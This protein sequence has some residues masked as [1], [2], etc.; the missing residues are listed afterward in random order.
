MIP[1]IKIY[2]VSYSS[3]PKPTKP[4]W[5]YLLCV[6]NIF[7]YASLYPGVTSC[8]VYL[9]YP[10]WNRLWNRCP[11]PIPVALC[12][13]RRY[14]FPG[15]SHPSIVN[16]RFHT[17]GQRKMTRPLDTPTHHYSHLVGRHI[18]ESKPFIR[19]FLIIWDRD[20]EK[21]ARKYLLGTWRVAKSWDNLW[22]HQS[23]AHVIISCFA[24]SSI[25]GNECS[26]FIRV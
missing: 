1:H 26:E 5:F 21:S 2:L 8:E 18:L 20:P 11:G 22:M 25:H 16:D 15:W 6:G 13:S 17:Q 23:G 4:L 24:N 10:L 14:Y 3:D 7:R 19:I 9:T 12:T